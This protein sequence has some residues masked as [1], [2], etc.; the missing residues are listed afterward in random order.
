MEEGFGSLGESPYWVV[1]PVNF[2]RGDHFGISAIS[3]K[4]EKVRSRN[5][6]FPEVSLKSL[7]EV[8]L[9]FGLLKMIFLTDMAINEKLSEALKRLYTI[10]YPE[11]HL[12]RG[13][14]LCFENICAEFARGKVLSRKVSIGG[15]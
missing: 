15:S 4:V 5:M 1:S 14:Y 12:S 10:V 3:T 8:S 11:D 13:G 7:L 6:K 9:S 2:L